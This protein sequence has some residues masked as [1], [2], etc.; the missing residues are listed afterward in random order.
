VLRG[1]GRLSEAKACFEEAINIDSEYEPAI[2]ALEDVTNAIE[3]E[4]E[5][6]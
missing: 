2:E 3:L 6:P 4:A 5:W 1:Q